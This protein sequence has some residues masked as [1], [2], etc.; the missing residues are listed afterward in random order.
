[1][2]L[3]E[4]TGESDAAR[5]IAHMKKPEQYDSSK[6]IGCFQKEATDLVE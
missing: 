6:E 4:S 2:V 3:F 5:N 1:M